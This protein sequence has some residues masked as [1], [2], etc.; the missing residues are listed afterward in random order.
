MSEIFRK[1][2]DRNAQERAR[3][4][5]AQR[6][7]GA[8]IYF[9]AGL[10]VVWFGIGEL[11]APLSSHGGRLGGIPVVAAL[12]FLVAASMFPMAALLFR[13]TSPDKSTWYATVLSA[14][15]FAQAAR[16][17]AGHDWEDVWLNGGVALLGLIVLGSVVKV[18][19][20]TRKMRAP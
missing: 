17:A 6:V 7:V 3:A 18:L 14:I 20:R 10:V 4:D 19:V 8:A 5:R 11:K 13:R 12:D 1:L 9:A 2:D 15:F 16:R